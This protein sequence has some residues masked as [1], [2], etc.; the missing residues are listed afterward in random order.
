[1][2]GRAYGRQVE[3]V[4]FVEKEQYVNSRTTLS[5]VIGVAV[6]GFAL[7]S[8]SNLRN[9]DD[10]NTACSGYIGCSAHTSQ[11]IGV[12]PPADPC[13]GQVYVPK[14]INLGCGKQLPDNQV[15]TVPGQPMGYTQ[16]TVM[17][18]GATLD[19]TIPAKAGPRTFWVRVPANYD[20]N[21]KY[22]VQYIG[23]GCGGYGVANT[24]T[25]QFFKEASGGTEE[26]I[27]V[28]LDIPTD[29]ANM[30]CYDNQAG[31]KSQEW[32]AFQLF[33][34]FV[35]SHYCVDNDRVY[36]SGYSTGGWLTDMWGCY[37]AGDGNAAWNGNPQPIV[38][39]MSLDLPGGVELT[40]RAGQVGD[41]SAGDAM[42]M[43][44]GAPDGAIGG[45][46]GAGGAAG[47]AGASGAGG[48]AGAAGAAGGGA[49][50]G[51][52]AGSG[53]GGAGG[54]GTG[55]IC[56]RKFAREYHIRAQL[57]VS[58]SEPDNQPPCNGPI[59]AI[60]IH[61]LMDGNPYAGNHVAA[62]G[63]VLKMDGC[64]SANPPTKPW[65]EDIM[66]V[67]VCV[68]YTDCPKEYPVV[69]C[70]TTGQGHADQHLRA[71]PG[72]TTFLKEMEAAAGLNK[73]LP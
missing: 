23:Q 52:A 49:G 11:P 32:E 34:D 72:F 65:H 64:F 47:A 33:H 7:G 12:S 67:G 13:T 19:G 66:G 44:S 42:S 62:L 14:K 16:F 73:A 37:F 69:F 60:W 4:S 27:Y 18:T 63:R 6:A 2:R 57:G 30:D 36:I 56:A 22:R 68:Q 20:P 5:I 38:S 10:N 35:D 31:A 15:P 29:K 8:C 53:A 45:A 17:G 46:G 41:A 59:S 51:G 48:A 55:Q 61:D 70:T 71:I 21:H 26:V 40:S 1:M 3:P 58:G 25:I 39:S 50:A 43:D 54:S 28:A 24:S 9:N